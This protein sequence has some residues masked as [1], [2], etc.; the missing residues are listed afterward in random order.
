MSVIIYEQWRT[1]DNYSNYQV[2][3][4]GR[5][6]NVGTDRILIPSILKNG[7]RQI[8]LY[9]DKKMKKLYVHRLVAQEFIDNPDEKP[10]VDH[11]DHNKSNN[12][13]NNLRWA[14]KNENQRNM[15]KHKNSRSIYKGVSFYKR[16]NKWVAQI[17][18]DG[19]NKHLGYFE[20]EK[21]A[22]KAYNEAAIHNFCEY[23]LLNE[24]SDDDD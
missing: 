12:C 10:L 4:F 7:Y 16:V 3:N 20:N 2:S 11:I 14:T 5:V 24:I 15:S 21:D 18:I 17:R 23:A 13:I 6:R 9:K 22:A 1:I 19:K 8:G